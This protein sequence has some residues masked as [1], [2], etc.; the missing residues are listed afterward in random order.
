MNFFLDKSSIKFLI[1]LPKKLY[2]IKNIKN[3]L[4]KNDKIPMEKK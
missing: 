4:Q 3:K 1:L 2:F